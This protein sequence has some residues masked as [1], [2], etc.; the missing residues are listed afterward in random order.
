[1]NK[2]IIIILGILRILYIIKTTRVIKQNHEKQFRSSD[3]V[4]DFINKRFE[5]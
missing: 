3:L 1:M 5:G 2:Y 4:N